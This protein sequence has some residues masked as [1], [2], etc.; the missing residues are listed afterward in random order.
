MS[1]LTEIDIDNKYSFISHVS[2]LHKIDGCSNLYVKLDSNNSEHQGFGGTKLR[3]LEYLL[4]SLKKK[5]RIKNIVSCGAYGS[6]HLLT[7]AFWAKILNIKTEALVWKQPYH[8][9]EAR[10]YVTLK[11]MCTKVQWI[12]RMKIPFL[13]STVSMNRDGTIFVP[14]GGDM[15]SGGYALY[16]GIHELDK[17]INLTN[18]IIFSAAGTCSSVSGLLAGAIELNKNI[19]IIACN[20]VSP[21]YN[22]RRKIMY[23]AHRILKQ[24]AIPCSPNQAKLKT[25]FVGDRLNLIEYGIVQKDFNHYYTLAQKNGFTLDPTY[26][27][28]TFRAAY[29]YDKKVAATNQTDKIGKIIYWH[30]KP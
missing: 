28:K 20:V 23:W 16:Q 6:F 24:R 10:N 9:C 15:L 19:T 14:V 7:L 22:Q 8:I 17:Q 26:T 1:F 5:Y 12:P 4:W 27:G 18:G 13:C 21:M 3:K 30:S 11:K 2:S 25:I 29:M